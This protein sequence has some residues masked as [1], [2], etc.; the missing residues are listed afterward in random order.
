MGE[1]AT[2]PLIV[3]VIGVAGSGKTTIGAL[4]AQ[5]LGV[6]YAEADAFHPAANVAK[7]AA[8]QPLADEDRWP[9]LAAIAAWMRERDQAGLG[10]V[11]SCSALKRRYRD[12]LRPAASRVWFVQLRVDRALIERRVAERVGH[13]MPAS[14]VASQF[15]ALEPLAADEAGAVIDSSQ[16]PERVLAAALAS[17]PGGPDSARPTGAPTSR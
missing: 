6:A 9:W 7:M 1:P 8:G 15:A 4:L 11:V 17:L 3:V 2:S 13:F 10:G 12:V 14:L 16:P 5:R